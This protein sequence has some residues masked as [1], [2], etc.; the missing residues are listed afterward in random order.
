MA[1]QEYEMMNGTYP[2]S[3]DALLDSSK[4]GYPFLSKQ[5]VPKDPWGNPYNY[6]APGSH[7]PYG[8]DLSCTS[9]KGKVI[10]NWE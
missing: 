10:N 3:L 2:S 9:P 1:I 7:N 4:Q 8:Y 5:V 6:A